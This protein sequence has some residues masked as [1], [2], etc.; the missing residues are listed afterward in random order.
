MTIYFKLVIFQDIR[1]LKVDND[2]KSAILDLIELKS[3][4]AYP[5]RHDRAAYLR[6]RPGNTDRHFISVDMCYSRRLPENSD[7][8]K[9]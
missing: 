8:M 5:T 1:H 7:I 6:R 9:M 3:F 2:R 4:R